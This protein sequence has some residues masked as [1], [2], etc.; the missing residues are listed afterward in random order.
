[1]PPIKADDGGKVGVASVKPD[2]EVGW[3]DEEGE[4]KN[5]FLPIQMWSS[6]NEVKEEDFVLCT[7]PSVVQLEEPLYQT[8]KPRCTKP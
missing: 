8:G 4:I 5:F 1:M 7:D 2:N 6:D 3:S